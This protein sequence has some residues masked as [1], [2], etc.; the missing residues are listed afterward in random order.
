MNDKEKVSAS[1]LGGIWIHEDSCEKSH[2]R[3]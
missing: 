3:N 1:C 2:S